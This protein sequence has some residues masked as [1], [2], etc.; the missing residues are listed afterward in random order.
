MC[1]VFVCSDS[2][3]GLCEDDRKLLENLGAKSPRKSGESLKK[4]DEV[5]GDTIDKTTD[6]NNNEEETN[7]N[8]QTAKGRAI[9]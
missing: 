7:R 3:V 5:D 8:L 2:G 6:N 4:S 9:Y 1:D